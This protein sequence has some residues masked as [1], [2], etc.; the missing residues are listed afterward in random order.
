[1]HKLESGKQDFLNLLQEVPKVIGAEAHKVTAVVRGHP[2]CTTCG[3]LK[4]YHPWAE[5]VVT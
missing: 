1:M 2:K 4:V 5:K 3:H